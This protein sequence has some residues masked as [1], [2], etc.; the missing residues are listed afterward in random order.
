MS[1]LSYFKEVTVKKL[2]PSIIGVLPSVFTVFIFDLRFLVSFKSSMF[3]FSHYLNFYKAT[4]LGHTDTADLL[5]KN[6]SKISPMSS[7]LLKIGNS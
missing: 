5:I 7:F 2:I 4:L 1:L 6:G 3:L